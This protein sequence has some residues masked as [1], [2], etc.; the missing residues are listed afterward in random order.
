MKI[1]IVE[2]E[3]PASERI[4]AMVREFDPSIRILATLRSVKESLEWLKHNA[5]PDLIIVDIQLN[6]GLSLD[7]FKAHPVPSP[8]V[9]TT[10]FDEYLMKAFEF[11]S[12][13]Y[14]LKPIQKVKLHGALTKYLK[15]KQHFT[16]DLVSFSEQ[17]QRKGSSLPSSRLIV[18]KGTDFVSIKIDDVAY[19]YTEHKIVF[20]VNN[21]GKRYIV[22]K[23][24]AELEGELD[25]GTFFRANRKYIVHINAVVS[26][27][28]HEKGKLLVT[29]SPETGEA[30]IV[31]QENAASF[32][33]W[34]GK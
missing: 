34:I 1:L 11:Y 16:G 7:I 3:E 32:K 26:F 8:L 23:P 13:D 17:F 28:S 4:I 27:K 24:L 21:V 9:F 2:D 22:D 20:L 31:S 18:K 15:L 25:T 10:A 14:L 30:V 29:L 5:A 6:D 12:I 33:Q 19:F